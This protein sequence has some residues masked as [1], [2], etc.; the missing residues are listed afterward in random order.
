LIYSGKRQETVVSSNWVGQH[1]D[2]EKEE[3]NAAPNKTLRVS[4]AAQTWTKAFLK[5][6]KPKLP[7]RYI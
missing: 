3:A 1:I 4:P 2:K 6:S 7:L 5:V